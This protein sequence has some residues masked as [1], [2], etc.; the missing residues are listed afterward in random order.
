M[1]INDVGQNAWE[2]IND[3]RAGRNYGW[4]TTEGDF[5]QSQFPNFTRPFY[6]YAHGGGTF[7][8]FAI[9]GGAFYNPASPGSNRFPTAYTGD[10]FFADFVNDWINVIDTSTRAVARF[11]TDAPGAVDL[12]VANDGSLYYLARGQ[13]RV[14]QVIY[15]GSPA[16]NITQHPPSR[17]VS[18]GGSVTFTVAATGTAPLSYQWQRAESGTS[19]WGNISGATAASYTL[20]NAQSSDNGDRFRVIVSNTLGSQTSNAATL[21]VT[22]NQAPSAA[23][24]INAGLT[25]N[26]F[27]AGQNITFSGTATDPEDGTLGASRFTWRVD[28]I[29]SINSGNPVV[30]PFVP[31]FSGQTSGNFTPATTG[32]YT[33]TDVAYRIVLTVTDA[34]GRSRTV[35][36]DLAPNTATLTVTTNPAGL[37]VTVDG[38]PFTSPRTFRS[39]VGFVR[40]IGA[41][42]SQSAGGATYRFV[43]WSDGGAATHSIRTPLASTTYTAA[44]R[45]ASALIRGLRAEFYDFTTRLAALPSL[46]GRTPDVVRTDAQIAYARTTRPWAGLNSRFADTFVSQHAGFLR[47]TRSGTYTFYLNSGDGSRLWID[48]RLI[49]NNNGLH[50]MQERSATV[51][52]AAGYHSLRVVFFENT[53]DAGLILS[54]AGPG[55]RKQV[56]PASALFQPA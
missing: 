45:L 15:T 37:R 19:A 48:G 9:T 10:Y 2:E 14:Y 46:S 25:N 18:S 53:G 21:T 24:A 13:G 55:I 7:Q 30:R 27:I 36:R 52:L 44:Y 54:W 38:Q 4:P 3:G 40:P 35:T 5:N 43:S 1:F 50:G 56:I 28:Y 41:A 33:L 6:A 51:A 16:P 26:R 11:A 29:T 8:G 34:G 12:R 49:V 20:S 39:V 23:I 47:V 22:A 31:A 42:A 17:T 32:P